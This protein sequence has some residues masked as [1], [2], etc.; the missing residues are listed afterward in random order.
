MPCD[1]GYKPVTS[2]KWFGKVRLGKEGVMYLGDTPCCMKDFN[3]GVR[4]R[5]RKSARKPSRL[6]RIVVGAKSC[7]PLDKVLAAYVDFD[8]AVVKRVA[9]YAPY[10]KAKNAEMMRICK[11]VN[12]PMR[13]SLDYANASA[14]LDTKCDIC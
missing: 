11:R 12:F 6:I 2:V 5:C 1:S 8:L 14:R 9:L 7:V 4:P 10:A 3:V 13:A